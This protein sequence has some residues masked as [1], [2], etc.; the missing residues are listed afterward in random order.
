MLWLN[1]DNV[2]PFELMTSFSISVPTF[3]PDKADRGNMTRQSRLD[4]NG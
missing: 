4:G 1:D 2:V 3:P